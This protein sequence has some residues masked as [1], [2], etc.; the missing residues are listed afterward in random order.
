MDRAA[1]QNAQTTDHYSNG[2]GNMTQ[3]QPRQYNPNFGQTTQPGGADPSFFN[4]W[5]P[6]QHQPGM[7]GALAYPSMAGLHNPAASTHE[8]FHNLTATQNAVQ[9]RGEAD[10]EAAV[11][12]YDFN[13]QY[14]QQFNDGTNGT[15]G[16][17][18][19]GYGGIPPMGPYY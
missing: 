1:T 7:P 12:E 8:D 4:S 14:T 15:R 5:P 6:S 2:L 13:A 11:P 9:P 16:G 10:R 18:G 17:Y 3:Y 19:Q